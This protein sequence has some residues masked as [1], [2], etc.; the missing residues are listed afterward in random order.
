MGE[1]MYRLTFSSPPHELEASGQ[2]H[3]SAAL[4]IAYEIGW[5]P[6]P[7]WTM[8]RKFVTLPG[9]RLLSRP[10]HSQSLYRLRYPG[11]SICKCNYYYF[12]LRNLPGFQFFISHSWGKTIFTAWYRWWMDGKMDNAGLSSLLPWCCLSVGVSPWHLF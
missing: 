6:E 4:P 2:L 8:W 7:V 11:L 5:T 10:A 3:A 1:W 9:L 12:F